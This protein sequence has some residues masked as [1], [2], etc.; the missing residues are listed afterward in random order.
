MWLLLLKSLLLLLRLLPQ[1]IR[2]TK[3]ANKSF[4]F[5][6]SLRNHLTHI[7]CKCRDKKIIIAESEN[8]AQINFEFAVN[9][10]YTLHILI[11]FQSSVSRVSTV[12]AVSTAYTLLAVVLIAIVLIKWVLLAKFYKYA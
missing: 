7:P 3:A 8:I 4:S 5:L 11:N 10:N 12:C 1:L 9:M 2:K 6:V